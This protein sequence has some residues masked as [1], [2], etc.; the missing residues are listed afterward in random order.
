MTK[1]ALVLL[2]ASASASAEP[3]GAGFETLRA[4]LA[5]RPAPPRSLIDTKARGAWFRKLQGPSDETGYGIRAEGVLPEFHADAER[6]FDAPGDWRSGPLD[7]ADVY[8]GLGSDASEV[9]AGLIW[10]QVLDGRGLPTG[11][12]AYRIYWRARPEGW[13]HPEKGSEDDLYF[14]SGERFAMTIRAREDGTARLDIRRPRDGRLFT[15]VFPVA[16]LL[17][18]PRS[19]KR[20]HSID[21]FRIEGGER[22]GNERY[23]AQPTRAWLDGGEWTSTHLLTPQGWQP[24]TGARATEIRGIDA[25]TRYRAIFATGEPGPSGGE[26]MLVVPPAR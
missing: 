13:G 11:E 21:Q 10:S 19:F 14:R 25:A 18:R 8:I 9:D 24:L 5:A 15:K 23:P 3:L 17:S 1:A 20:V 4:D 7:R 16:G 6:R 26:P 2:L 22:V 12:F